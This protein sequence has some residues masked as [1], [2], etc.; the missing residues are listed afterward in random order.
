[1]QGNKDSG[2]LTPTILNPVLLF[3]PGFFF[4]F[5][6]PPALLLN[7]LTCSSGMFRTAALASLRLW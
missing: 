6:F 2:Q 5:L 3:P 1:M 7:C 4:D